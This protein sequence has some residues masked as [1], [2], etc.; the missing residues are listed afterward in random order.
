MNLIKFVR[1]L[2]IWLS[3]HYSLLPDIFK[4]QFPEET[5]VNARSY[6]YDVCNYDS[7]VNQDFVDYE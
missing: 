1:D 6:M 3:N 4:K 5:L 2:V 7:E